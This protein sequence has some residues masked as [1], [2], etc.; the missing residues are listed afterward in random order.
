MGERPGRLKAFKGVEGSKKAILG[1]VLVFQLSLFYLKSNIATVH[2]RLI[3]LVQD[4]SCLISDDCTLLLISSTV[5]LVQ[6]FCCYI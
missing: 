3:T 6:Y 1:T 5:T 4:D 2:V